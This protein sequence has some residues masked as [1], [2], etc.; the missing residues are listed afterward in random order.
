VEEL[1]KFCDFVDI[2]YKQVLGSVKTRWLSLQPAITTVTDMFPELKSYFL[3]QEKCPMMLKI[4][5][6]DPV[7]IVWFHFL[8]SELKVCCNTIKK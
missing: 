7:S 2:E 3:S 6:N 1:E 4:F 8:E 5:F